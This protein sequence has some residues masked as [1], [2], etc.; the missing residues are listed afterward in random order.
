VIYYT[1]HVIRKLLNLNGGPTLK[2]RKR[3][4]RITELKPV[5]QPSTAALNLK[6]HG[7]MVVATMAHE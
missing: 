4:V 7:E 3:G 6:L 1:L 2:H 5:T